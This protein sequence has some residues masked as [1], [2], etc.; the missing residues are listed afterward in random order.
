M[1]IV[2]AARRSI[3]NRFGP[4]IGDLA[5]QGYNVDR[6]LDQWQ[7]NKDDFAPLATLLLTPDGHAT[8]LDTLAAK[9]GSEPDFIRRAWQRMGLEEV[10]LTAGD[11]VVVE[12]CEAMRAVLGDASAMHLLAVVGQINRRLAEAEIAEIRLQREVPMRDSA[13]DVTDAE[14]ADDIRTLTQAYLPLFSAANQVIHRRH[15]MLTGVQSWG[16]DELATTTV[17]ERVIGFTDL[18]GFTAK[19]AEVGL[20]ELAKLIRVFETTVA[21]IVNACQGRVVKLIGDE[22]MFSAE[23]P[24]F[25]CEI[26]VALRDA[27]QGHGLM[28]HSGLAYGAV[29]DHGGDYF[30]PVVN[31]AARLASMAGPGEIVAGPGVQQAAPTYRFVDLGRR[32]VRGFDDD[33]NCSMLVAHGDAL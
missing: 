24:H 25:G 33:Q 16:T 27:F 10:G 30:G 17:S 26:A 19:S 4:L 3:L 11:G 13:G 29:L 12:M 14:Y 6:L 31:L 32:E 23:T 15:L 2:D 7:H 22:V 9:T 20:T 1:T 8:D 21:E 18:A 28:T 5:A